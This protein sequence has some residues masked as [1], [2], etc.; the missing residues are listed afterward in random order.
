MHFQNIVFTVFT[1]LMTDERTDGQ[2]ENVMPPA[3]KTFE[4]LVS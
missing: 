4:A 3:N 1:R 2:V